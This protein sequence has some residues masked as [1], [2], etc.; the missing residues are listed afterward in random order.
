MVIQMAV[1]Q[2]NPELLVRAF[3]SDTEVVRIG[4]L[5]LRIVSWNFVAQGLI[6]SCSNMF[7]GLGNTLPSIT[8]SAI[9]LVTYAIPAIWLSTRPGFR[10]Q[11]VW[12]WSIVATGLQAATS[13]FLLRTQF[14]ELLEPLEGAPPRAAGTVVETFSLEDEPGA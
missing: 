8:S 14:R 3:S 11:Y 2:W 1:C 6:F 13:L 9:R 12:Y 5:F 7:Q 4:A 10:I